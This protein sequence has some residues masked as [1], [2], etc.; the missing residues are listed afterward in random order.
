[1]KYLLHSTVLLLALAV[2]AAIGYS[3]AEKY[4]EARILAF[5][6]AEIEYYS[7]L[8]SIQMAEGTDATREEA[9]RNHLALIEKRKNHTSSIF[10]EKVA[11]TDSALDYAR[12]AALAKK[13]GA[14]QESQQLLGKA[15][16]FCPQMGWKECNTEKLI[17]LVLQL[18]KRG[19]FSPRIVQ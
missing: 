16:S 5:D 18:D 9:I 1:M 7:S 13:R 10:T 11:A 12:L 14:D 15:A 2:G 8:S 4:G 19:F 6:M 3:Y 17:S